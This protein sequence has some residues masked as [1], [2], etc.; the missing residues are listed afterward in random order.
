MTP[1]QSISALDRQ[2]AK[3]GQTVILRRG[4]TAAGEVAVKGFVRGIKAEEIT[5]TITQSDKAVTVSPTGLDVFGQPSEGCM[6][7][8]D[9]SPRNLIGRPEI[10]KLND[11]I[12][13]FNMMVKG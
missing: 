13:R 7:V 2:L 3:H 8:I 5:G 6:V 9:G 11:T 1:E 4:N 10:I 12:V